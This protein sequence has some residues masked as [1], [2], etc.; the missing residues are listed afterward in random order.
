M[1]PSRKSQ[2]TL[3]SGAILGPLEMDV[4]NVVWQNGECTI[5]EIQRRLPH[6]AA[7][8]TVVTTL[9]RLYK[10]GLLEQQRPTNYT[11]IY[12]AKRNREEWELLAAK[13]AAERFLATPN[14][15]REVLL[16]AFKEAAA[17]G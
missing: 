9:R 2:G 14:V 15:R 13:A 8:T 4:M 10:K 12:S 5:Q 3:L 6:P 1:T 16:A 11:V 7:Y 17:N